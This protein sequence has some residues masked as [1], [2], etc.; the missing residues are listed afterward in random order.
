MIIV[1]YFIKIKPNNKNKDENN[2]EILMVVD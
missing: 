2:P 1:N